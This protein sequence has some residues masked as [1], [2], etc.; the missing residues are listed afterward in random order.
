[1]GSSSTFRC[2]SQSK[3]AWSFFCFMLC[4]TSS[5]SGYRFIDLGKPNSRPLHLFSTILTA[6]TEPNNFPTTRLPTLFRNSSG[7]SFL[8]PHHPRSFADC[9]AAQISHHSLSPFSIS[10]T[11]YPRM[12]SARREIILCSVS[13]RPPWCFSSSLNLFSFL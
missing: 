13:K 1:M 4:Q 5:Y 7:Y 11:L 3:T 6:C 9:A 2:A 8:P 10:A 12:F